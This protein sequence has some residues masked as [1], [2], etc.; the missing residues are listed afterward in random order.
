[1]NTAVEF[2][3]VDILFSGK[4]RRGT[5]LKQ[6]ALAALDAGKSRAQIS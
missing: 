5:A 2:R 1:M 4:S 3:N 6:E